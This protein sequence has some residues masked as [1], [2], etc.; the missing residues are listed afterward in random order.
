MHRRNRTGVLRRGPILGALAVALLLT[1]AC[2][3]DADDVDLAGQASPTATPTVTGEPSPTPTPTP[4]SEASGEQQDAPAFE[5]TTEDVVVEGDQGEM[6]VLEEVRV[7]SHDGYD[8]VVWEFASGDAPTVRV[9]YDDEPLEPGRGEP[10]DVAGATSLVMGAEPAIDLS[11]ELRAPD[12]EPYDGPE[13]MDGGDTDVV[14]EVVRMG[15]FEANLQW[16]VGLESR[17]PYR[18]D[19][20]ADPL[21]VVVDVAH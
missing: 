3:S 18:V 1:A 13:R 17:Q 20:L 8:R 6:A 10:I 9:A 11:T 21:R 16:A 15:D 14:T 7:A 19:V 2:G 4:A 5:G 12:Q